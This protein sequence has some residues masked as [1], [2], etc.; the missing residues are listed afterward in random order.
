EVARIIARM[1]DAPAPEVS[2]MFRDGD[3][4]SA[5]ADIEAAG[6]ELG[7]APQRSLEDGLNALVTWVDK[8]LA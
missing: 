7:W 1:Y 8:V 4:R 5:Y 2:G 3:V 6:R